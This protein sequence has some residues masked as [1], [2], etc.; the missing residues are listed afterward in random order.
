M[1]YREVR[2]D[3]EAVAAY[4]AANLERI[5]AEGIKP[6]QNCSACHY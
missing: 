5:A 3:D 6:P 1:G 4:V 2:A